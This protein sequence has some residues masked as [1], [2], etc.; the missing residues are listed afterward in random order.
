MMQ[1]VEKTF[2][3]RRLT[4][5]TGRMAK[6][7]AGAAVV[8]FGDTMVLATV[9]VSET[10]SSLPFFPLTVE[11][12]ERTYAAGKIPGGFIKR[13]GRPHDAE[14]LSARIIDRSIRPLFPEGFKNEV[15]V[16]VYVISADQENDADVLA[17][18]ATSFALNASKVPFAGTIAGVRIGRVQNKWVLNPTFQQLEYS[19]M[20]LVVAGSRDSIVMVEGGALEVNEDDVVEALQVAH[21]GIAELIDIQEELLARIDRP[22]KMEWTRAEPPE[23][24][25]TRVKELA[26]G[27]IAEAI[28]QKDKHTR[29]EAV[30]RVKREVSELLLAEFPDNPKDIHTLVGDVEYDSL[31]SQVLDTGKRVDGRDPNEVRPISIDTGLLPRAH[32]SALFTRGQTQALV[33]TTLGTA[34]DVQRLDTIDDAGETTKSFMLHYNFPPFSTGEV[35]PVR[36]TSR[37]EIGHGNL[38]ERALQS[39]LPPFDEFPYTIRIVSDVLESNGSSSMASVCGGSLAMMD[40]GVPIR[41]AVAG[42]AMGLIKEGDRYAILTDILGT[43]DH[44]GDLDFKVAGTADGITAIQMDMKVEGL[45]V[46]ILREALTRAREGRLHILG[47]MNKALAQPRE[48]LSPYAPRI[49]TVQI[50][51]EKIGDLIGPKG[52]TIRGIQDETG[53]EIT[54]D[55]TGMVTIAAVGGESMERA[56]QMVRAVTAEPVVGEI[57]EGTVKSTTAFGAFVEIMPGTEA[58]LHISELRHGRTEKTE[59]VVKKGDHVR[60]KLIDRDERGR[61]RLSMKA[62]EP[63]PGQENGGESG[64]AP[65]APAAGETAAPRERQERGGRPPR[66]RRERAESAAGAEGEQGA[67]GEEG[68]PAATATSGGGDGRGRRPRRGSG[69]SGGDRSRE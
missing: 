2:A 10:V 42:V 52:K 11:Y 46:A 69:R 39:V 55:D 65:A 66:E 61:L 50:N 31:R 23:G 18:V 19:D 62:L 64:A 57:Y 51:P 40:A 30:A 38:A 34:N 45:D 43:E 17:L 48:E 25:V 6:Q 54:V 26:E 68:A 28:N 7:A 32:G 14:I 15:Q 35:R 21:R 60:V 53:A 8:R 33:V 13:E 36:G 24:M 4:I 27:R 47:E 49:V 20:E 63:A 58:L 3:G 56:R 9:T 67:T 59:D 12:K 16:F 29:I 44:L 1:R 41:A 37:R 5:E 22:A